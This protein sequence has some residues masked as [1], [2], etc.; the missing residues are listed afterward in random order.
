MDATIAERALS[1]AHDYI[2]YRRDRGDRSEAADWRAAAGRNAKLRKL[3]HAT[4][5]RASTGL[6]HAPS[7]RALAEIKIW[8][9]RCLEKW[10]Q[11][12]RLTQN[13]NLRVSP[14]EPPAWTLKSIAQAFP[15][16]K[17]YDRVAVL[18]AADGMIEENYMTEH[19]NIRIAIEEIVEMKLKRLLPSKMS[20]VLGRIV[21]DARADET[22]KELS[23]LTVG[24]AKTSRRTARISK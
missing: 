2:I 22:P 9:R 3:K 12:G 13:G 19:R 10:A 7:S 21:E 16:L 24:A 1:A 6:S 20:E 23:I 11:E 17:T 15:N 5:D 4:K 18:I 8:E 14:G